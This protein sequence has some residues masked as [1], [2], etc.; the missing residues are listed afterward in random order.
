MPEKG[1]KAAVKALMEKNYRRIFIED[2]GCGCEGAL[3]LEVPK[4]LLKE[5][6]KIMR[7]DGKKELPDPMEFWKEAGMDRLIRRKIKN[8]EESIL[9]ESILHDFKEYGNMMGNYSEIFCPKGC[10]YLMY[11]IG[12]EPEKSEPTEEPRNDGQVPLENFSEKKE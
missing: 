6:E 12:S 7:P 5:Y 8:K 1:K 4:M 3:M 10:I 2:Y 9:I 11:E